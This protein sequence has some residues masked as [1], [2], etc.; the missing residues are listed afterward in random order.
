MMNC[1]IWAT[2]IEGYL[3]K[4]HNSENETFFFISVGTQRS[5]YF[6]FWIYPINLYTKRY[7]NKRDTIKH[8][9][10]TQVV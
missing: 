1:K 7:S 2:V 8:S 6:N 10:M 5:L 4:K 3:H 9:T